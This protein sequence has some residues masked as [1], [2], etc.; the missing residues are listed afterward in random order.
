MQT[1]RS[2]SLAERPG[3][4]QTNPFYVPTRSVGTRKKDRKE[5]KE[6]KKKK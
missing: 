2:A 3:L 1:G 5:R 4:K 6:K